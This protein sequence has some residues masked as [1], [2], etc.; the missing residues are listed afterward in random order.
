MN[1]KHIQGVFF[2]YFHP[3]FRGSHFLADLFY[4][5]FIDILLWGLTSLWIQKQQ[6]APGVPLMLMTAL[7]FWHVTWRGSV[8]VSVNLLQEFWN[9]NLVNLFST[10]LK[11][12]EWG[13]GI[14]LLCLFKLMITISFGAFVVYVLYSLNIFTIGWAFLPFA[15]N[16]LFLAGRLAFW[17]PVLSSI[18]VIRW[19]RLRGWL[20]LYL[21]LLAQYFIHL[22]FCHRGL[23]Q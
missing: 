1:W 2:R 4:W 8:D 7:I 16:L 5:P 14:I 12:S 11:V 9:R 19:K 13:L 3:L 20:H 22:T 15:M 18:G 23:R 6:E 21:H 10:P 17:Q